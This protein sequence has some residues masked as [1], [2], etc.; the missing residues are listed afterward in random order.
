MFCC[1]VDGFS[2]VDGMK[3]AFNNISVMSQH[4]VLNM[5]EISMGPSHTCLPLKSSSRGMVLADQEQ[6]L[7]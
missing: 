6:I 5:V 7:V 2:T 1:V 4:S 3:A